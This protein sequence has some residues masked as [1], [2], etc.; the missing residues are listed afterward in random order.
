MVEVLLKVV[1]TNVITDCYYSFEGEYWKYSIGRGR[2]NFPVMR[3]TCS[4]RM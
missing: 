2:P 4:W 3:E 1:W